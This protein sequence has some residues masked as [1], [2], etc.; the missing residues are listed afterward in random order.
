[1]KR[2]LQIVILLLALLITVGFTQSG[3]TGACG[4]FNAD[5]NPCSQ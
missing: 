3:M 1:M 5:F 2:T 4:G